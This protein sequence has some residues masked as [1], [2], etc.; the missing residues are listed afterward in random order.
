MATALRGAFVQLLVLT[1]RGMQRL[2]CDHRLCEWQTGTS[3]QGNC[4]ESGERSSRALRGSALAGGVGVEKGGAEKEEDPE[5]APAEHG[6]G[7]IGPLRWA[8]LTWISEFPTGCLS[9][10]VRHLGPKLALNPETSKKE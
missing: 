6:R 4:R 1:F 7:R 9:S 8:F 2:A 10:P 5:A 3:I